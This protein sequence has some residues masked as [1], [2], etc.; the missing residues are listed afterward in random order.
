MDVQRNSLKRYFFRYSSV[1][2]IPLES[3]TSF[4]YNAK[5]RNFVDAV[6]H[7]RLELFYLCLMLI[8]GLY[9]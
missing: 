8:D 2:P 5:Y 3:Q 7:R 6:T 9:L 4:F 1:Y